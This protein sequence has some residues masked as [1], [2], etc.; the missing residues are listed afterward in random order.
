MK[1]PLFTYLQNRILSAPNE[2]LFT[3]LIFILSKSLH[4]TAFQ[5]MIVACAKPITSLF[6][7]YASSIL[8]NKPH[9]I[10]PYIIVN[11]LL[12]ALPCFFFPFTDNIWFYIVSY[13]IFMIT[14]RAQE[15]A[16]IEFLKSH[17]ELP[18]MGKIVS[19]G[20]AVTYT[21]SMLLPL[22]VSGWLD[23]GI[24]KTIYL[25]IAVLQ[26]MTLVPVF[27]L[28]I[29][30]HTIHLQERVVPP[31]K[32]GW[33]LL[34][35]NPPFTHY[36]L[37]YC[38]GGVGIVLTQPILPNFFNE[39]LELSYKQLTLAFSFCK[40]ISFLVSSPIWTKYMPYMSIYRMN[41]YMNVFTCLFMVGVLAAI[42]GT[43]WL[44]V[45]YLC[46]GT[47]QG[48]CEL[49]WNMSGPIFSK[50]NDS[51]LYSSLNLLLVGVRGCI[52]PF[53][54]YILFT[55][56]GVIPTFLTALATCLIGTAYGLWLDRKY[57]INSSNEPQL[58]PAL[59]SHSSF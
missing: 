41:A 46:Y 13:I 17:L 49:S 18:K 45:A 44:Y 31:L 21:V 30:P 55:Y 50:K 22:L 19:Y 37:L 52:C 7:F 6:S 2:V 23:E 3:F 14:K 48:G 12:G 56:F 24:W 59:S 5:L 47:M 15:P 25:L 32:R 38:L 4:A 34:R 57:A 40:G 26:L 20:A 58:L 29:G 42:T 33:N 10:R 16:W 39:Y 9:F 1:S 8:H 28:K 43:Q 51:T 27:F 36:L 35:D 11:K 53:L 54:G